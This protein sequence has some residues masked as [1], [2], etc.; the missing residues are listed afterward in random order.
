VTRLKELIGA[1]DRQFE[2][3]PI[4][5]IDIGSNS[6]RLVVYEGAVRSL[7]PVFNEKVLC[8]LGR[9][10]ATTGSLGSDAIERA[11]QALVRFKSVLRVLR[12]KNVRAIATAAVRD[13][14]NGKDF[15]A[16]GEAA[17]GC[18]IEVLSGPKEAQLAAMG[19]MMG[20]VTPDGIAG[21]LGGGSLELID[22]SGEIL[23]DAA[24][25]PLGGLRLI[26]TTSNKLDKAMDLIDQAF[27]GLPWLNKGKGRDFYA[28]G[29]TWRAL[30]KLHMESKQY[31]LRVMHGYRL[32]AREALDFCEAM[33]KNKKGQDLPGMG[34]VARARRE[35]LPYGTLVLERLIRR[36][37]PESIVFSVFGIR[38]GLIYSQLPDSER[39]RDPLLSFCEDYSALRSRSVEHAQELC[40]WTDQ[41]FDDPEFAETADERRLRH[42]ACLLSDVGWRAHPDYRGE[43]SL[44]T[45][46]HA[47][48]G[49]VDHS[50][51][52]FLALSVFYRHESGE[53]SAESL[54]ERLK[55]LVT[56]RVL[57]RA[58]IMGA[59]IRV[60]HMLSIGMPGVI[61]ETPLS[62]EG[63]K[64]VLKIPKSYA[65]LDGERLR[66]RFETLS[67]LAGRQGDI[68]I[69]G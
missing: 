63:G 13:A 56:K 6:V 48:L 53:I 67:A 7:T 12:V 65:G 26:D 58:R 27:A 23:N 5:I 19:I 17:A 66:R 29:G 69:E 41:L 43:Q 14:T 42:A 68:R 11:I 9:S 33:R 59:A 51:R 15:I 36:M 35:V 20:F 21:D 32:P 1:R 4:A 8:G 37:Q 54:P 28:V 34:D 10:V 25:L 31:P 49:G 52:V 24:T 45:I 44:N 2:L 38:E 46:A 40:R 3:E 16:W 60:A 50:G 62:H 22:M 47:G 18:P 30:A 61:D 55:A 39:H 57:K 64:L